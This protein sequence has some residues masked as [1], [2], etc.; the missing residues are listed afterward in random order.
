[1]TATILITCLLLLQGYGWQ[2]DLWKQGE[3]DTPNLARL[4]LSQKV[5]QRQEAY[6]YAMANVIGKQREKK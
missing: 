4:I 5:H 3:T 2:I 6:R 1:M